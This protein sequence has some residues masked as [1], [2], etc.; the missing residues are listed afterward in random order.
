VVDRLKDVPDE[1]LEA[2]AAAVAAVL[3]DRAAG[4]K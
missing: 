1:H 4:A 2:I 3:R